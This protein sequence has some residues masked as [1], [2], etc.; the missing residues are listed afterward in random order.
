MSK[1]NNAFIKEFMAFV[2]GFGVIGLAL[3]VVIGGAASKIVASLVTNLI[4]PALG[5]IGGLDSLAEWTPGGF[6]VG[7]F[8]NDSIE[9]VVLLLVV[10]IAVKVVIGKFLSA[11]EREEMGL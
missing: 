2:K 3:G 7:A 6:G 5:L 10:Y 8:I 4:N 9:F 11:K 1:K